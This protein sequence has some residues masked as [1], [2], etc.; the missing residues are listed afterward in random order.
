MNKKLAT[1]MAVLVTAAWGSSFILMKNVAADVPALGFLT[2]R[3]GVAGVILSLVFIKKFRQYT[4]KTI[5]QSF[6]L[7]ALLSGYMIFQVVGLRDENMSASNS[8]FITS[9]SVL[10]VPFMSAFLLKKRPSW[11]NW[12]GVVLAIFGLV[13]VTGV[14]QGVTALGIGDL[15][16][17]L[18]AICVAIHIIVA[19]KYLKDS[20]P[21]LLGVGQI[22]AAFVLSFIAW[23]VQTPASFMTV[24]YTSALLMAVILTAVFCTCFAFTGQIVVQKHL[25][26]ARVAVIFTLEPVFAY[27][28]ALVIPGKNGMTEQLTWFNILGSLLIVGGMIISESGLLNRKN[29]LCNIRKDV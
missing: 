7:G 11:S 29:N 3:F 18:C 14:Y 6:V 8:A 24:D 9:T 20:D 16:T 5:F 26:P 1:L 19:D 2:L 23:T 22:V 25:P 27:L 13:F 10:M 21:I 15:L 17:F 28:Y 12:V 4:G